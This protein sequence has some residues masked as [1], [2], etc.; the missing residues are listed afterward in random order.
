MRGF[1]TCQRRS[2]GVKCGTRNSN[3]ARKC[4]GCAKPRSA[5]SRSKPPAH[6]AALKAPYEDFVRINGGEHCGICKKPRAETNHPEWKLQRDHDHH[7]GKPRGLLCIPCN[8]NLT[9]KIDNPA[10]LRAAAAYLE[11]IL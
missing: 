5:A 11:R 4:A 7:T 1:W 2:G 8:R 3:R 6:T 9:Q 10:W